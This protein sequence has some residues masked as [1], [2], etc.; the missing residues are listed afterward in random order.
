MSIEELI[1]K[2]IRV[3]EHCDENDDY[4]RK[5]DEC[6]GEARK[7]KDQGDG[8]GWNFFQ[9]MRSGVVGWQ[10]SRTHLVQDALKDLRTYQSTKEPSEKPSQPS[11]LSERYPDQKSQ[12][13]P[14]CPPAPS[15]AS[16]RP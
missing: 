2:A 7:W 9:G 12:Q 4:L 16:P 8:Y 13:P 5:L 6:E 10:V 15:P 11:D 3:L 14:T 1:K